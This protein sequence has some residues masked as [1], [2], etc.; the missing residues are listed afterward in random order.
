MAT[1][2]RTGAPRGGPPRG[3]PRV[4]AELG[5]PE[6]PDE[7]TARKAE[8]SR[9][10]RANQTAKNLVLALAACLGVVL[11]LVLIVVR[12]AQPER[13]PVDYGQIAEQAQ[14]AV[15]EPL[16]NPTLPPE[17][18]SNAAE[19][20][21]GTGDIIT[22]SI[23]FITPST[24]FIKLRQG[25]GVDDSWTAEQLDGTP[26]TGSDT[27]DGITWTV[28]DDRDNTDAGN[29]AYAMTSTIESS[30]IVLYGTADDIE[31]RTLATAIAADAQEGANR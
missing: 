3:A 9:K 27:I 5:R 29:F 24:E 22:W 19:L 30:D 4:V 1:P 26:Q 20:T 31:F 6:T 10:H 7:T 13:E 28:H 16:A 12:P 14:L 15:D 2:P 21:Q 18:T 23:G 11:L 17:W 25:I 8:A